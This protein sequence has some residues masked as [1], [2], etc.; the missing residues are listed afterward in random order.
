M[1]SLPVHLLPCRIFFRSH[2]GIPQEAQRKVFLVAHSW[3]RVRLSVTSSVRKGYAGTLHQYSL[4]INFVNTC[5]FVISRLKWNCA[6]S[7]CVCSRTL[8][9]GTLMARF[10]T[11]S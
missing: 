6:L 7:V 8:A 1:I 10:Q 2:K 11:R 3:H 4:Y 9:A 5:T